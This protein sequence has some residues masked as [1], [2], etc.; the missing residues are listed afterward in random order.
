VWA[1]MTHALEESRVSGRLVAAEG[2]GGVMSH[3]IK[4]DTS[5]VVLFVVGR[6]VLISRRRE[7]SIRSTDNHGVLPAMCTM[8][9]LPRDHGRKTRTHSP[10]RNSLTRLL[11]LHFHVTRKTVQARGTA[12]AHHQLEAAGPRHRASQRNAQGVFVHASHHSPSCPPFHPSFGSLPPSLPLLNSTLL[13]HVQPNPLSSFYSHPTPSFPSPLAQAEM[14]AVTKRCD[15][16]APTLMMITTERNQL[17]KDKANLVQVNNKLRAELQ[18][19]RKKRSTTSPWGAKPTMLDTAAA[20]DNSTVTTPPP[21]DDDTTTTTTSS[22]SSTTRNTTTPVATDVNGQPVHFEPAEKKGLLGSMKELSMDLGKAKAFLLGTEQYKVQYV[23]SNDPECDAPPRTPD[24]LSPL[25][26]SATVSPTM[27]GDGAS[28]TERWFFGETQQAAARESSNSN[29]NPTARVAVGHFPVVV[30]A[31]DNSD[32]TLEVPSTS[33]PPS[34]CALSV[35][36]DVADAQELSLAEILAETSKGSNAPSNT[37]T[38]VIGAGSATD[39]LSSRVGANATPDDKA[40]SSASTKK[41]KGK[42]AKATTSTKRSLFGSLFGL[43]KRTINETS[44]GGSSSS[45]TT[46]SSS[47]APAPTAIATTTATSASVSDSAAG[48][49]W[50][51]DFAEDEGNNAE[52]QQQNVVFLS[53]W[54]SPDRKGANASTL[55]P[56]LDSNNQATTTTRPAPRR[57]S[58]KAGMPSRA[59][60]DANVELRAKIAEAE[61][62]VAL[63]RRRVQDAKW[64]TT[65]RASARTSA[66][67]TAEMTEKEKKE[68]RKA[69]LGTKGLKLK[70]AKT[71]AWRMAVELDLEIEKKNREKHEQA[72]EASSPKRVVRTSWMM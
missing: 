33:P 40:V 54:N 64:E 61:Q 25:P 18:V 30:A 5:A 53:S 26:E 14:D 31:Q 68:A 37:I 72:V 48:N 35:T 12:A 32:R 59:K 44:G 21:S 7:D 20:G 6:S 41:G 1:D 13:H 10:S 28:A 70:K 47:T 15:S 52:P 22:D 42:E 3:H 46:V 58:K 49:P 66:S 56:S 16:L 38:T 29:K 55:N 67:N 24:S 63:A 62:V 9:E 8:H 65:E 23:A 17:A 50:F 39:L 36:L 19:L 69:S 71:P 34:P 45:T 4:P 57:T 60:H 43:G 27:P 11:V 2:W 51:D